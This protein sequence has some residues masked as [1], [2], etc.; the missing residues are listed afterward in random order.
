[1]TRVVVV[2]IANAADV[3]A[4][5]YAKQCVRRALTTPGR[6]GRP[7]VVLFSEV[8]SVDVAQIASL[9]ARSAQVIQYGDVGS[10]EA[11]VAIVSRL[12][13]RKPRTV[14]GSP[15]TGEGGGIRMR[16]IV[17]GKTRGLSFWSIHAPPPRSPVARALF[18]ARCRARRGVVAGDWNQT[19]R[20]MR[21]TSARKYRAVGVLGALIPR[22]F[23]PSKAH[24]VD[25][26]SDHLAVDIR[27]EL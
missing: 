12:P 16:P 15:K 4:R 19:P 11:G 25:I 26:G 22:R 5:R 17:G 21:R 27:L 6:F 3:S 14:M 9:H 18:I 20:W 24:G 8:S 13:L 2:R 23:K 10:P 1:M 7:D